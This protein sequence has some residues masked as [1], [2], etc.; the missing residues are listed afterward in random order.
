MGL[1]RASRARANLHD[2]LE[3]HLDRQNL[4]PGFRGFRDD[5]AR[6]RDGFESA[7]QQEKGAVLAD[8]PKLSRPIAANR[9]RTLLET[10][11]A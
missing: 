11:L 10:Y 8:S 6:V 9:D 1:Y 2:R 7:R 4:F 3:W 5:A